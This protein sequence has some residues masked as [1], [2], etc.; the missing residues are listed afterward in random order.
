MSGQAQI[1]AVVQQVQAAQKQVMLFRQQ[2]GELEGT[3]EA[4]QNQPADMALHRNLGG[5]MVEVSDREKLLEELVEQA[6][7]LNEHLARFEDKEKQ[8]VE[9][10]N[11]MRQHLEGSQ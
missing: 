1:Q 5:V 9:A 6:A 2:I 11:T 7:R 8:L 4:V 10:Y 3:I